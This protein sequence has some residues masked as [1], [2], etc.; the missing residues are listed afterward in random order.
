LTL[1]NLEEKI[2]ISR[3]SFVFSLCVMF[4][5]FFPDKFFFFFGQ[6]DV[7]SML[8]GKFF[9]VVLGKKNQKYHTEGKKK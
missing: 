2:D 1:S 3:F 6:Y 8:R 9:F 7:A 4:L 5:F